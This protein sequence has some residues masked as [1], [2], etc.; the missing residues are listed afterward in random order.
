MWRAKRRVTRPRAVTAVSVAVLSLAGTCLVGCST[1]EDGPRQAVER[2]AEEFGDHDT[3]AAAAL[4][5]N[6]S[7]ATSDM[8][9]VWKGLGAQRVSLT[10][11]KADID[12]GSATVDVDYTW[13]LANGQDWTYPGTIR[14]GNTEQG[15]QVRWVSTNIHPDL[16]ADQRLTM[17][18]VGAP[19]ATVNESDGSEVMIN[20]TVVGVNF[21]ARK[22]AES[23]SVADSAT[24]LVAALASVDRSLSAQKIAEESTASEEPY[25]ITRISEATFDRLRDQLAIPG[26]VTNEQAELV[27]KDPRFAPA[28]LSQVKKVVDSEVDGRAGWRIVTVNP[29]GSDA[30]VLADHAAEPAPAVS[31][32][33]S[34]TVQ[35]AAQNAVNSTGRFKVAMVVVQPS[36]GRILGVAQNAYADTEGPIATAGLYPPGSTFKMVTAAAAISRDL[37]HPDTMVPCPG[38][39]EIGPRRIPNYDRFSLGTVPMLSAFANSCNTTFAKLASE[40]GPSDLAHTA[41]AMGIGQQYTIA[42]LDAVSGSVP[43]DAELVARAEDGFGQGRVLVSPLGLSLVAATV[44]H[45]GSAPVPQ[46]ILGKQTKVSG[47]PTSTLDRSVFDQLR[48]MMRAVITE[49]TATVIAGQGDVLGKTGEAEFNGG[50]H[51]WF[52]GYRGDLAFATLVV[53]GGDSTNAVAITRDFFASLPAGYAANRAP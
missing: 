31:L 13:K 16:G 35:N 27:A 21:D 45:G 1:P 52:A 46:L 32:T 2:F 33:L 47:P 51:A 41:A 9:R 30:E 48:P 28:L 7:A 22:A 8:D 24:R 25:P 53:G 5:D 11:G 20:G 3:P 26:V 4:T 40:M 36:T 49:G 15:W 10:T 44:A 18:T 43:I 34:R 19:R 6:P 17:Q 23:G 39:I 42:G 38:E 50:S 14:V 37:A 12:Q 29:N